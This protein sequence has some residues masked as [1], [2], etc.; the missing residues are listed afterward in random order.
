MWAGKYVNSWQTSLDVKDRWPHID[1]LADDNNLWAS[2]AG[3]RGWNAE[4]PSHFS[5]WS[6]MKSALP[7]APLIIG[8]ELR[9]ITKI[10]LKIYKN[11]QIIVVNQDSLGIRMQRALGNLNWKDEQFRQ[12][13]S[14]PLPLGM[15]CYSNIFF[16]NKSFSGFLSKGHKV[17]QIGQSEDPGCFPG[18]ASG[19]PVVVV[20]IYAREQQELQRISLEGEI[21]TPEHFSDIVAGQPEEE[22]LEVMP[23]LGQAF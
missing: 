8:C 3:P 16:S 12:A 7:Q 1:L 17:S 21:L 11:I 10:H 18:F 23:T 2:H 9:T 14:F 6:I 15:S 20:K 5:I 13:E 4:Y 22:A 19:N